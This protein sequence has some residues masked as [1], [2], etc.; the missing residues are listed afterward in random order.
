M[1]KEERNTDI[2]PAP[3][4]IRPRSKDDNPFLTFDTGGKI[5]VKLSE[6]SRKYLRSL[7]SL[8]IERSESGIPEQRQW[9]HAKTRQTDYLERFDDVKEMVRGTFESLIDDGCLPF[10]AVRLINKCLTHNEVSFLTN[11]AIKRI[12]DMDHLYDVEK[13]ANKFVKNDEYKFQD[14]SK[15]LS[16]LQSVATEL[17]RRIDNQTF[18]AGFYRHSTKDVNIAVYSDDLIEDPLSRDRPAYD[19]LENVRNNITGEIEKEVV[20]SLFDKY[21]YNLDATVME[22]DSLSMLHFIK[23]LLLLHREDPLKTRKIYYSTSR[24]KILKIV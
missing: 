9:I 19:V 17:E 2:K 22:L 10:V 6:K 4:D 16:S 14:L 1:S 18:L 12:L 3:V 15:H 7:R 23:R 24:K 11:F 5:I 13:N 21:N 20:D 8:C